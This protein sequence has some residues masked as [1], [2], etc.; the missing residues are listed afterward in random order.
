MIG[1][2]PSWEE[3]GDFGPLIS[4]FL[5]GLENIFQLAFA[6]GFLAHQGTEMIVP[7]ALEHNKP[8]SALFAGSALLGKPLLHSLTDVTPLFAAVLFD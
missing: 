7:P 8:L 3:L 6:P 1:C 2:V 4:V 5:V